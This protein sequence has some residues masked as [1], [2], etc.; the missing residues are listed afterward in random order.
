VILRDKETTLKIIRKRMK[1]D[2]RK[3]IEAVYDDISSVLQRA[4]YMTAPEVQAVLDV[5][6]GP[7]SMRRNPRRFTTICFCRKWKRAVLSIRC[8]RDNPSVIVWRGT[9]RFF[10][11]LQYR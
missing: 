7:K 5:V 11:D 1:M 3:W 8:I 2:N 9:W 4:P 10:T 6:K